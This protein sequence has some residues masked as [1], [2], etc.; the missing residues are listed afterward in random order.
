[1]KYWPLF[2]NFAYFFC[3]IKQFRLVYGSIIFVVVSF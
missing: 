1:M 2:D 3:I